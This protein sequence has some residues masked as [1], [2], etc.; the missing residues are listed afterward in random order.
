M[1]ATI[2][3]ERWGWWIDVCPGE[4]MYLRDAT[5]DDLARCIRKA[6]DE[7][8]VEDFFCE[9]SETG[10]LVSKEAVDSFKT[11]KVYAAAPQPPQIPEGYK[12]V[13]I[14]P[15]SSMIA[16]ARLHHEGEAYL[17][18]SLYKAMLEAAP[19]VKP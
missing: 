16:A 5:V 6:G 12:I 11:F 7:R 1:K 4:R 2:P 9:L 3:S 13:P 14:E 15:T 8:G 10:A 18:V 19:E 17:P